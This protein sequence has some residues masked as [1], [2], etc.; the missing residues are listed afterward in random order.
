MSADVDHDHWNPIGFSTG[1]ERA[2]AWWL[3]QASALGDDDARIRL[4]SLLDQCPNPGLAL[5]ELAIHHV[6]TPAQRRR[7]GSYLRNPKRAFVPLPLQD[8]RV[9]FPEDT[10]FHE[11]FT[12]AVNGCNWTQR[13]LERLRNERPG[14]CEVA[15]ELIGDLCLIAEE[16]VRLLEKLAAMRA[17]IRPLTILQI[18]ALVRAET[19]LGDL[20]GL[21]VLEVGPQNGELF[22]ELLRSGADV[23]AV[24]LGPK[25]QHPRI[26]QGDF[27]REALPGPFDLIIATAVFE[28]SSTTQG[29]PDGDPLNL[30]PVLLERFRE[31]T[32]ANGVIVLENV[33]FP[34]PFSKS[35][36]ERAGFEVLNQQVPSVNIRFGGRGCTLRR[37]KLT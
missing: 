20:R 31:L 22:L 9:V 10:L 24:D 8:Y 13:H 12:L 11:P 35:D 37:R 34:I 28:R 36:A 19:A 27:M 21:K 26:I 3:L 17:R 16:G 29:E 4:F 1:L 18:Q 30:T 7:Y 23:F 5:L 33:L 2:E 25:L 14:C 32:T 6:G 15:G